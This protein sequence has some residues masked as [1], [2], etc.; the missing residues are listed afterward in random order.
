[1]SACKRI[2]KFAIDG[3]VV[4]NNGTVK[5]VPVFFAAMKPSR[6]HGSTIHRLRNRQLLTVPWTQNTATVLT[7][8]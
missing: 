1:M 8:P 2:N 6:V 5:T 4:A 7:V 3:S